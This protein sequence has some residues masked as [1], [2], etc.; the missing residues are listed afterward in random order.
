MIRCC[1][2]KKSDDRHRSAR[3]EASGHGHVWRSQKG[4][5]LSRLTTHV[6]DAASGQPAAGLRLALCQLPPGGTRQRLG[7]WR[8]NASGRTDEP[9]LAGAAF[10][11]GEYELLFDIAAW[12]GTVGFYDAIPIRFRI[13]DPDIHCHVP[14]ILAPFGYSTYRGS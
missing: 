13:A 3:R 11:P 4:R 5:R 9:L 14:L 10:V 1:F 6:L 12:R 7:T 8:T 2:T